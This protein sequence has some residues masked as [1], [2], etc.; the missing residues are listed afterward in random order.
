LR[1]EFRGL[2]HL[3]HDLRDAL[4]TWEGGSGAIIT[5]KKTTAKA[6]A[7]PTQPRTDHMDL[8]SMLA[9]FDQVKMETHPEEENNNT[10]EPTVE[11]HDPLLERAKHEKTVTDKFYAVM[12]PE[13]N[14]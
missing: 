8:K 9:K 13:E 1:P 14:I 6:T 7:G 10:T 5:E 11:M 12:F 4:F 2:R 3:F